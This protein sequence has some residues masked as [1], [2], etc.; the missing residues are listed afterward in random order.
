MNIQQSGVWEGGFI[1]WERLQLFTD[2][3]INSNNLLQIQY[4][5]TNMK[6][7][8]KKN[9]KICNRSLVKIRDNTIGRYINNTTTVLEIGPGRGAWTKTMLKYNPKKII[10]LDVFSAAR[11]NFWNFVGKENM[12]K[13]DYFQVNDF[14][15]ND[16]SNN[17]IDFLFSYDVFCH[18]SFNNTELYL[19][20]LYNKFKKGSIC[21]IMI[22]DYNKSIKNNCPIVRVRAPR[23]TYN[24]FE[25][26][27]K[28]INGPFYRGRFFYY[29]ID[30]FCELLKKYNYTIINKDIE[31]DDQKSYMYF[32]KKIT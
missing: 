9:R 3:E 28:D 12:N 17:S 30:K 27:I 31:L 29:G 24:S 6:N 1:N 20:N 18:I 25:E 23:G 7:C 11:N 26:E 16:I 32:Y 14:L 10:C 4:D 22:A 8:Y 19:K 13:I 5:G 15:C 2:E 21:V